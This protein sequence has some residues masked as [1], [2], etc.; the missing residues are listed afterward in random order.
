MVALDCG[1]LRSAGAGF[2]QDSAD[3][4]IET[5]AIGGDRTVGLGLFPDQGAGDLGQPAF[6]TLVHGH[7]AADQSADACVD[8]GIESSGITAGNLN[9]CQL[10]GTTR[11]Q[12]LTP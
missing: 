1:E 3:E 6:D 4:T 5:G 8:F 9:A 12:M 11:G 10:A 2:G 7:R